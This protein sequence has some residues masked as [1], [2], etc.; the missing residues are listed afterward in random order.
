[1]SR[2][3][4]WCQKKKL[5]SETSDARSDTSKDLEE[6]LVT[7]AKHKLI[8]QQ[9]NDGQMSR[10]DTLTRPR[11]VQFY[12]QWVCGGSQQLHDQKKTQTNKQTKKHTN[13]H[14]N[15]SH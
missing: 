14:S 3:L 5:N 4:P 15:K 11:I 6:R 9:L 1:M 2:Q 12:T 8:S 7:S 10:R 13:T